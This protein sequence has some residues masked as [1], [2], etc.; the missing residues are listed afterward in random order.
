MKKFLLLVC[1]SIYCLVYGQNQP[2]V[3]GLNPAMTSFCQ[4]ACI[5][6]DIDG[7]TGR[8]DSN[9]RGQAPP[10]FCTMEVHHMQWIGFIAGTTN[11]E[12][13]VSLSNCQL[14][15]GLEIGLYESFD[16][17]N[18]RQVSECDTDIR[19]TEIRVF[20]N[21]V[22]LVIGQYYYFVMDGNGNDI[23]NWSIR[24]LKGSTRV[25]PLDVAPV[26]E[27][28]SVTCEKD[29][30][31]L[32]TPG[33]TGATFYKWT[34]Q[35]SIVKYGT[36]VKHSFSKPGTYKLCL[37]ASNVCDIAPQTCQLIEV[38][39]QSYDTIRQ[40]VC[41]GECF[42]Y[43]NS[44]Y[45]ETGKYEVFLTAANGCDSIVT[46]D[47]TVDQ[48]ITATTRLFI[49][50][51]DTL[52]IGN[53]RLSTAGKHEVIID[54]Q[55]GCRIYLEVDL[56]LIE[57]QIKATDDIIPVRCTGETSGVIR[58]AI[59]V[60][61]PPISYEGFKIENP[62]IRFSGNITSKNDWV[63]ISDV[64]EGYYTFTMRDTFG[65]SNILTVF[66][67]QPSPLNTE[68]KKKSYNGF[69]LSCFG[70]GDGEI[71]WLP[72]GGTPPYQIRHNFNNTGNDTLKNL[73]AGV[74][75]SE[76]TDANGCKETLQII[77]QQPQSITAVPEIYNPDCNG[78]NTGRININNTGGGIPPYRYSING[79]AENAESTFLQLEEGMYHIV[80]TDNNGCTWILDTLL[81]AAQIPVITN[82]FDSI[83]ISLGDSLTLEITSNLKEQNISWIPN[84]NMSCPAC[85]ITSAFP[86]NNQIYK[87][88]VVSIDG[89]ETSL[90]I[91]VRVDKTRS[92][93]MSNI[94]TPN[95]AGDNR[96]MRY[97]A[98]KDVDKI[99]F[100][101]VF[102]RW[103]NMVFEEIFPPKGLQEIPWE[104]D[105]K[106]KEVAEGSYT[107]LAS[108]QYLDGEIIHYSGSW[109]IVR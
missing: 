31:T 26:M 76:V 57:C 61:T 39:P 77:L 86:V 28:P 38:L 21:T 36:S 102:D 90:E 46:L 48:K 75:I 24:V 73:D 109:T 64:D 41:Y 55:E 29:T 58:F 50:E 72:A 106:G 103:G 19:P 85:L 20:K 32:A 95:N 5:I 33:L 53:G 37:D 13:E 101:S 10:D 87:I 12:I 99:L 47:L 60:G 107:W 83:T 3:C 52:T 98:G 49:C 88:I 91:K 56:F 14:N 89:C 104:A 105:F 81:K 30:F 65:N 25:S 71:I 34:I 67:P 15:R 40:E 68:V 66:V 69:D 94:H 80:I 59:S 51:G 4:Q 16:C 78:P 9:I 8:N 96:E 108:V 100:I 11:L 27:I 6:C 45:C 79:Q 84:Q 70:S 74:Y 97:Y 7:F 17:V 82:P 42:K 63:T 1:F 23:C 2:P 54:N 62:S 93:V 18:F 92:F 35:D 44:S 22:P 43:L